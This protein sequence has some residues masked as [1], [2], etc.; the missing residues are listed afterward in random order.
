MTR[1]P[2]FLRAGLLLAVPLLAGIPTSRAS[3]QATTGDTTS[4]V[5][6]VPDSDRLLGALGGDA[7]Q[8]RRAPDQRGINQF[9]APKRDTVSYRGQRLAWGAAFSQQYQSLSHRNAALPV[10]GDDGTDANALMPIVAGRYNTL[11]GALPG[12]DDIRVSRSQLGAGW[13]LNRNMLLKSEWVRQSYDGFDATDIRNR[14]RF[15]GLMVE[16]AVSF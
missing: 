1:Q 13:F 4:A 14:G 10:T 16:A 12:N 15:R 8:H 11:T 7:I 2:T 6:T 9:E 5:R 3:A